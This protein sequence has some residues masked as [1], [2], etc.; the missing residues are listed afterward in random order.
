[1]AMAINFS[2]TQLQSTWLDLSPSENEPSESY[3]I[4]TFFLRDKISSPK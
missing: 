1:M 3:A 4:L 2:L